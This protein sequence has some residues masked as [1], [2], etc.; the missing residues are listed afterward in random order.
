MKKIYSFLTLALLCCVNAAYAAVTL[1]DVKT[2]VAAGD[3]IFIGSMFTLEGE[4]ETLK[5]ISATGITP[6]FLEAADP[7]NACVFTLEASGKT[8]AG[9]PAYYL[10]N[11]RTDRY[12]MAS[13]YEEDP[14]DGSMTSVLKFTS[15]VAQAIPVAFIESSVAAE[16][17]GYEGERA[18]PEESFYVMTYKE[19]E[20]LYMP[21]NRAYGAPTLATYNDWAAWY[22]VFSV[23]TEDNPVG[24]LVELIEEMEK[25]AYCPNP[26][27]ASAVT[28]IKAFVGGTN[29]GNRPA[30]VVNYF[31]TTFETI[32]EW[33]DTDASAEATEEDFRRRYDELNKAYLNLMAAEQQPVREGTYRLINA[34]TG[35]ELKQGKRM[36][37]YVDGTNAMW[38]TVDNSS[39]K[40]VWKLTQKGTDKWLLQNTLTGL[41]FNEGAQSSQ[42][43]M[44]AETD[45]YITIK[46]LDYDGQFNLSL[47]DPDMPLHA[48]GHGGGTGTR[49]N[50]VLWNA[51]STTA[52][53]WYLEALT[54]EELGE[55]DEA[56]RQQQ[57]ND[58]LKALLAQATT[59]YNVAAEWIVNINDSLILSADQISSNASQNETGDPD[60][61]GYPALID[62]NSATYFHSSWANGPA[63]PH[64]LQ[65]ALEKEVTTLA[66]DWTYRTS[67]QF[68][69]ANKPAEVNIYIAPEGAHVEEA[70]A[71][72]LASTVTGMSVTETNPEYVSA[73]I[74]LPFAAKY[75][76]WEVIN[77]ST[78]NSQNNGQRFF[79][80]GE[81]QLYTASLDPNCQLVEMGEVGTALKAAIAEASGIVNATQADIDKLQAA[82]DAFIAHLADPTALNALIEEA[83]GIAGSIAYGTNPGTYPEGTTEE[84][85]L[86][87]QLT[88]ATGLIEGGAYTQA[89]LAEQLTALQAAYDAFLGTINT[90]STEKWYTITF[91]T[92]YYT[93]TGTTGPAMSGKH[94]T[95]DGDALDVQVG[96]TEIH[97]QTEDDMSDPDMSL[98]RF[99]AL[100]D[101]AYT[102]QNKAT[103]Y[104]LNAAGSGV[105][106][107][108]TITPAM[109]KVSPLG[110]GTLLLEG[111][112]LNNTLINPLHCQTAGEVVVGW[113]D[114]R[115]GSG[116]MWEI[117]EAE[118]IVDEPAPL[119]TMNLRYG[120]PYLRCYPVEISNMEGASIYRISGVI[121]DGEDSA[122]QIYDISEEGDGNVPAGEPFILMAGTTE[123]YNPEPNASDTVEISFNIGTE[124]AMAPATSNY[125][126]GTYY[127]ITAPANA[128]TIA[129]DENGPY[130]NIL[131]SKTNIGGNSAY[132]NLIDTKLGESGDESTII[133]LRADIS[134]ILDAIQQVSAAT[135][136]GTVDVYTPAGVL[137]RKGVKASEATKG[138][139]KGIYIVGKQKQ[140]VTK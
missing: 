97:M 42:V 21:L 100:G 76:R 132:I 136:N 54:D 118:D 140:T 74:E 15:D 37:M 75:V 10:K 47:A 57:L 122:L 131:K 81:F 127:G 104:F 12:L 28:N 72:T 119:V 34:A 53:A 5:W 112:R 32:Y 58:N 40:F 129:A 99:I 109:W 70:S 36:A 1:G 103:G 30:E 117:R 113:P 31:Y 33:A 17:M 78:P 45:N 44:A 108:T 92:T 56:T 133:P 125:L 124:V 89:S 94:A 67:Q 49:G 8:I 9:E 61:G 13:E 29:P 27:N 134:D 26:D 107:T 23:I 120:Q 55:I 85:T 35:F 38:E 98:W 24:D 19:D 86:V 60:G 106:V 95:L 39:T 128:M 6:A 82:Y 51:G 11:K 79:T 4:S 115:L 83:N 138:L 41:Y 110:Y 101:S 59:K 66:F 7:I 48:G 116:S 87:E 111:F 2:S 46:A 69:W 25:L 73:G 137:V 123:D 62:G 77:T 126:V 68:N 130:V 91:P 14:D 71:W 90:I 50:I 135:G 121:A 88:N 65:V 93:M 64:Y 105:H 20:G 63:A 80:L 102:I 52:S 114:N 16:L 3:E 96:S 18:V 139:S 84:E 43:K 22:Q